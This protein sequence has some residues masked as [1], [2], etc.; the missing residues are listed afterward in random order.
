MSQSTRHDSFFFRQTVIDLVLDFL[1]VASVN[2]VLAHSTLTVQLLF[3]VDQFFLM[4]IYF[5]C[6][7]TTNVFN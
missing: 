3:P 7:M 4:K 1:S 2:N 5:N 6:S